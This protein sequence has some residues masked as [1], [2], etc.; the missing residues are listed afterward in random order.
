MYGR[1]THVDQVEPVIEYFSDTYELVIAIYGEEA[2]D[3]P[4]D[5]IEAVA[6]NEQ[7]SLDDLNQEIAANPLAGWSASS[8]DDQQSQEPDEAQFTGEHPL[9]AAADNLELGQ[10]QTGTD[11]A[12]SGNESGFGE[13]SS[14]DFGSSN[15]YGHAN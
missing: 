15:D 13:T 5:I 2:L 6:D 14:D 8:D 1:V 7:P 9:T 11:N 4:L 12:G 10:S 3:E